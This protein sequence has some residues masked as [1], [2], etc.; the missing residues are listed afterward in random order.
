[1]PILMK[2][3]NLIWCHP[4]KDFYRYLDD[5]QQ[6]ETS[7]RR[8]Q[9]YTSTST[10]TSTSNIQIYD[11]HGQS[12][13]M[14]E[15]AVPFKFRIDLLTRQLCPA[16]QWI[17]LQSPSQPSQPIATIC[18]S[19]VSTE[20]AATASTS[21]ISTETPASRFHFNFKF[22]TTSITNFS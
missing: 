14:D 2:I 11:E 12:I 18:T 6:F 15:L 22:P 7:I 8:G 13:S 4:T 16:I 3:G 5:L 9:R 17:H 1:M 20:T 19:A 21:A 10:S